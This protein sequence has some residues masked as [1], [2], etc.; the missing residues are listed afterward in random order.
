MVGGVD[1]DDQQTH[2]KLKPDTSVFTDRVLKLSH[3]IYLIILTL[4]TA[5]SEYKA[6]RNWRTQ[7]HISQNPE[8]HY[9]CS[10]P[11]AGAGWLGFRLVSQPWVKYPDQLQRNFAV[12]LMDC[13]GLTHLS[14]DQVIQKKRG[15]D[16]GW[17]HRK[18]GMGAVT[19]CQLGKTHQHCSET[20]LWAHVATFTALLT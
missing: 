5:A 19:G 9:Y 14:L 8:V 11:Q 1:R 3:L 2:D 12:D 17:A 6:E 7:L 18:G 13:P 4:L 16:G 10:A 15:K 20:H